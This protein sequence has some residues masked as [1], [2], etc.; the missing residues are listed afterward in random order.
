MSPDYRRTRTFLPLPVITW[1][2]EGM[3]WFSTQKGIT[4]FL[5][6]TLRLSYTAVH[7]V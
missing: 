5:S 3:V 7:Y 1:S 6:L 2:W 4:K